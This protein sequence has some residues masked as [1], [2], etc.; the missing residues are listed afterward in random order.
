MSTKNSEPEV[1]GCGQP[2][3][4]HGGQEA[5]AKKGAKKLH[6]GT[7]SFILRRV[8]G[9]CADHR[10]GGVG[11]GGGFS[12]GVGR[13]DCVGVGRDHDRDASKRVSPRE[14][15]QGQEGGWGWWERS[16]SVPYRPMARSL[17][18]SSVSHI[19]IRGTPS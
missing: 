3:H 11:V 12:V 14:D 6:A 8:T 13:V 15:Q 9:H 4:Y 10:G 19:V 18:H 17:V 5:V 16:M 1:R 7:T 2:Q